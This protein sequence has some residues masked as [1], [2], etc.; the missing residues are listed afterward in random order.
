MT[1]A[2]DK[3]QIGLWTGWSSG[4]NADIF[5]YTRGDYLDLRK[6]VFE[7]KE[8][9]CLILALKYSLSKCIAIHVMY[10]VCTQKT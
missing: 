8:A 2:I 6:C 10:M 4:S 7:V 3:A 5:N 9:C 1:G